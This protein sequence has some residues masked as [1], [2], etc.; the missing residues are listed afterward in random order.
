MARTPDGRLRTPTP[1]EL[2]LTDV[3]SDAIARVAD[4]PDHEGD[5]F[6]L[7]VAAVS[8]V[9]DQ[10]WTPPPPGWI[11]PARPDMRGQGDLLTAP[12]PT[13]GSTP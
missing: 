6:W 7:A 5:P 9:V 11:P 2:N 13:T 1:A 10:G 12:T 4:D 8:A 3:V